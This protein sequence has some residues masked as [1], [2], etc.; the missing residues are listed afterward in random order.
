MKTSEDFIIH[1]YDLKIK[2][3]LNRIKKELSKNNQRLIKKYHDEMII[4]SLAKS[5]QAKQLQTILVLSRMLKK[6]WQTAKKS[7]IERISLKISQKFC[8]ELGKETFYSYDHKKILKIFFRWMKLG[9]RNYPKVGDPPETRGI[10]TQ[11]VLNKIA[12]K[13]LI[14]QKDR[15]KLLA[16]CTGNLRDMAFIDCHLEAGTRPS[17]ILNMRIHHVQFDEIG[18][19]LRVNGKTGTRIIRIIKSMPSLASWINA[20]PFKNDYDS[21]LWIILRH[22][23]F[24]IPLSYAAAN[25]MVKR[26]AKSAGIKKRMNLHLFRHSSATESA[27]YLTDAQM[28]ERHGWSSYSKVPG[29]YVH[30]S[31]RDIDKAMIEHYGLTKKKRAKTPLECSICGNFNLPENDL[32]CKCGKALSLQAVTRLEKHRHALENISNKLKIPVF[33]E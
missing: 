6:D 1:N 3:I 15:Q 22:E 29:R 31:H 16:A 14:T 18:A 23:R 10:K 24:G 25:A 11:M 21:P 12:R 17:E 9:S 7:D 19:I 30:L 13:D 8:D 20:H 33:S 26:R 32:C 2:R 28:R 5:T 27:N 4:H